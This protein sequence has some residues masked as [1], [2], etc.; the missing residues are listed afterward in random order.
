MMN[1]I[2]EYFNKYPDNLIG[3]RINNQ[4]KIIDVWLK[5]NWE[6]VQTPPNITIK[7]QKDNDDGSLSYYIIYGEVSFNQLYELMCLIIEQNISIEKKQGLFKHKIEELKDLFFTLSYEELKEIKFDIPKNKEDILETEVDPML[8]I[9]SNGEE[10]I[11]DD[12]IEE[13]GD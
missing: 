3:F 9:E 12:N 11:E 13:N 4:T 5:K 7:K 1:T 6:L 2:D 10:I 8:S